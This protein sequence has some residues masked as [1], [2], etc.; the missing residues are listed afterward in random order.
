MMAALIFAVACGGNSKTNNDTEEQTA[1]T[2]E[3]RIDEITADAKEAFR[4]GSE[5]VS[6]IA[7]E[8]GEALGEGAEEVGQRTKASITRGEDFYNKAK[9]K[10]VEAA[11][12]VSKKSVEFGA[13]AL[14]KG[15][16][17][18]EKG[19]EV[20]EKGSEALREVRQNME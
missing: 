18:M 2:R 4:N 9:V 1:T 12:V 11:D 10:V 7:V 17:V 6:D 3:E 16:E 19:A 13:V 8:A 5:T 14:E 20:M 15:A